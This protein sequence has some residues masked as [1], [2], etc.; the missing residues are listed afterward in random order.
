MVVAYITLCGGDMPS[1]YLQFL[2]QN[3]MISKENEKYIIIF[4]R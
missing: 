1:L 2:E 3:K 4:V